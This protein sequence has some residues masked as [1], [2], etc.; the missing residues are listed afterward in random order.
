MQQKRQKNIA[1][2]LAEVLITLGIIGTVAALTI[3]TLMNNKAKQ[4]TVAKLQ[5]EY[6][7]LSQAVKLSE[8]DNGPNSTW[9]WGD[10]TGTFT[11][12]QSFDN[13]WAPYIKIVKYCSTNADCGY[14]S[15][16]IKWL[17]HTNLFTMISSSKTTASLSDG[18]VIAV[19]Y[20]NHSIYVDINAGS[21]PNIKGKDIFRFIVD[22]N[23]GLMPYDY[24]VY[25]PT[26]NYYCN[27]ANEWS[28]DTCAAKIMID[29]WQ[30][31]DD[32][33]W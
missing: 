3:P 11:P 9:D 1:F 22:S 5:K 23:K 13:Y 30:I 33:P 2:T 17:D 27:P 10:G 7:V 32:Y 18:T 31:K 12:R 14:L 4:E 19:D 15:T 16:N 25:Y 29:G 6:T 20:G 28:G 8:N 24:N 26:I 21:S